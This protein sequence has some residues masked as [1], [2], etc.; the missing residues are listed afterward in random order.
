MCGHGMAE[1]AEATGLEA[2]RD[3]CWTPQGGTTH[4]QDDFLVFQKTFVKT[5][6]ETQ[7]SP[8]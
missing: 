5:R 2:E 3:G 4:I 6:S 8:R 1:G 7:V